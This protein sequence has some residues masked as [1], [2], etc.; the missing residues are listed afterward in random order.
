MDIGDNENFLDLQ[1]GVQKMLQD[2][3]NS[4]YQQEQNFD[5]ILSVDTDQN[6]KSTNPGINLLNETDIRTNY[7]LEEFKKIGNQKK[8]YNKN[9]YI[10]DKDTIMSQQQQHGRLKMENIFYDEYKNELKIQDFLPAYGMFAQEIDQ[11]LDEIS[12][13]KAI[14]IIILVL[15]YGHIEKNNLYQIYKNKEKVKSYINQQNVS[16]NVKQMINDENI[17]GSEKIQNDIFI[18]IYD[19]EKKNSNFLSNIRNY[20]WEKVEELI[21]NQNFEDNNENQNNLTILTNSQEQNINILQLLK[22]NDSVNNNLILKQKQYQQQLEQDNLQKSQMKHVNKLKE[23]KIKIQTLKDYYIVRKDEFFTFYLIYEDFDYSLQEYIECNKN[24]QNS[25]NK[26]KEAF[27]LANYLSEYDINLLDSLNLYQNSFLPQNILIKNNQEENLVV[28]LIEKEIGNILRDMNKENDAIQQYK[29]A[30]KS[31]EKLGEKYKDFHLEI[32]IIQFKIGEIMQSSEQK[33]ACIQ[34]LLKAQQNLKKYQNLENPIQIKLN[35]YLADT[36]FNKEDLK[37]S[38][39]QYQQCMFQFKNIGFKGYFGSQLLEK[40]ATLYFL[41][42]EYE[43]AKIFFEKA[44]FYKTQLYKKNHVQ[45]AQICNNLAE[46]NRKLNNLDQAIKLYERSLDIYFHNEKGNQEQIQQVYN[47]LG[48]VYQQKKEYVQADLL[49]Q[50]CYKCRLK[51]FGSNSGYVMQTKLNLA[52]I[53]DLQ[54]NHTS[55]ISIYDEILG[56]F[57]SLGNSNCQNTI[58]I[59]ALT[60]KGLALFNILDFKGANSA[61]NEAIRAKRILL[62][63]DHIS[64]AQTIQNSAITY[65]KLGQFKKAIQLYNEALDIYDTKVP[66][67]HPEI[68]KI[69]QNL[70]IALRFDK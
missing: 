63:N 44:L 49:L 53:Q 12:D 24:K 50:K 1:Q 23:R 58:Y 22:S 16:E 45:V 30:I 41:V 25:E 2:E 37:F 8:N 15:L 6:K 13:L 32:G 4:S 35:M 42:S 43:N 55:S 9:G 7:S 27:I 40:L 52:I 21:N 51:L 18:R 34:E 64:L 31:L 29:N 69:K 20:K 57:R 67:D 33:G 10:D 61:F 56:F 54:G 46:T 47:N 19:F 70:L 5:H 14:G 48:L 39:Q 65:S 59:Q 11:E 17:V 26:I 66:Q 3:Y 36:Y 68:I 28:F 62:G 38:L 60:N